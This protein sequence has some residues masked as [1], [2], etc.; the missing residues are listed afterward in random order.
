[1][2]DTIQLLRDLIAIDSVNPSLVPG[3]A[4]EKEIAQAI[5]KELR[6][7][8]LD[9]EVQRVTAERGNVIGIL[10]GRQKGRSLMFCGH[11]D[12]VGVI[13]MEAPFDPVFK[14]GKVYGRGSQDMKGGLVSMI[15][16][17]L[18]LSK[19]G[20]LAAG[21]VIVAAVI[22]E[23]Y[24]SI[25]ADA[26]V[27]KWRAD[28]AVVG[29]PTDMK[30]AVGHKG[31]EWVEIT[32]NGIAAHGSRARDG[33]DAILRMGRVLSR[34]E[35]LDRE[36]QSRHPHPILGT[37]SLHASLID[38]GRELSTYPDRCTLQMERRLL[39]GEPKGTTLRDVE[40]ILD[41]LRREDPEFSASA[42]SLF[43]RPAY[44]TPAQHELPRMIESAVEKKGVRPERAGATFWTDAAVLGEAGIPSVVF[45]PGGA[46]LHG[47]TEYVLAD[48]V[49]T[50]R[51]ALVELAKEFCGK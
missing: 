5:A 32:T 21:R 14:D 41:E 27:T 18:Q 25:G 45:G 46:G 12:T 7:G 35:K 8:G 23:E 44:E 50:C 47:L 17:A 13:G 37:G 1:M 29:E 33:R 39:T 31:F 9:V 20:G 6:A 16:A 3:G 19:N 10:E 36:I 26:L 24:A 4:G 15:A 22:D 34:L 51:D 11:M 49:I 48:D 28:A 2:P 42:R 43:H 40:T 30:I 38:G